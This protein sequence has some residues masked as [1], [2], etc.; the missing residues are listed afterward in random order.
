L[1]VPFLSRRSGVPTFLN[2]SLESSGLRRKRLRCRS[3]VPATDELS[4]RDLARERLG[5]S[6]PDR[7]TYSA[8]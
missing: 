6:V 2:G 1:R 4:I 5:V 8:L 7:P 3:G